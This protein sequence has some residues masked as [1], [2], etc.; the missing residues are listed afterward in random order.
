[1]PVAQGWLLEGKIPEGEATLITGAPGVGKGMLM[2][3]ITSAVTRGDRQIDGSPAGPAGDVVMVTPEDDSAAGTVHRLMAAGAVLERC[4]DATE[5]GGGPF[6]LPGSLPELREHLA[7]WPDTRLVYVD[8]LLAV[9]TVSLAA[10]VTVRQKIVLP[11]QRLARDYGVAVVVVDH[12]L[13]TGAARKALREAFRSVLKVELDKQRPEIRCLSVDKTNIAT[14]D[15]EPLRY[16]IAGDWPSTH[17]VFAGESAHAAGA[18]PGTMPEEGT[19]ETV[20]G[21]LEHNG[22]AAASRICAGTRL[23]YQTVRTALTVLHTGRM[24][25]LAPGGGWQAGAA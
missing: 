5:L 21:W 25:T 2:A 17:A 9:S 12:P 14:A 19:L 7:D 22:P 24:V 18:T 4:H 13:V 23:D 20:R 6:L 11:L 3:A 16:V 8:P 15:Q 1:V 10:P